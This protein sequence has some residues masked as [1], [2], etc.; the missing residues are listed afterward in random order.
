MSF[1]H[2]FSL[3]DCKIGLDFMVFILTTAI[4]PK[5][6]AYFINVQNPTTLDIKY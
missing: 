4:F 2:G 1:L 6:H 5:G 3:P